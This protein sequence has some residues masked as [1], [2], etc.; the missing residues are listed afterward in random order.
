MLVVVSDLHF[1]EESSD[2]IVGDGTNAPIEYSRNLPGK[3]YQ[4]FVSHLAEEAYRN[5][6]K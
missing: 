2:K 5:K 4:G 6:A 3:V 1:E